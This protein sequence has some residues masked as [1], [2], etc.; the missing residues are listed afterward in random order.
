M[1]SHSRNLSGIGKIIPRA[2]QPY[3]ELHLTH[4]ELGVMVV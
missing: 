1:I 2:F 4:P 3:L